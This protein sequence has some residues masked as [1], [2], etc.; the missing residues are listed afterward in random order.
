MNTPHDVGFLGIKIRIKTPKFLKSALKVAGQGVSA[1]G[2]VAKTVGDTIGK[3]PVIGTPLHALY[4][5]QT[6]QPFRIADSIVKGKR[7]DRI[8]YDEFKASIKNA[9]TI[10]PYA[11]SVVAMVPGIGTGA[12]GIIGAAN[13]LSKGQTIDKA[14]IEGVRGAVPGGVVARAA[15]DVGYAAVSGKGIDQIALAAIPLPPAQKAIIT[16]GALAL[17][18]IA[19]GKRVD[20]ALVMRAIEASPPDINTCFVSNFL[21]VPSRSFIS[22]SVSCFRL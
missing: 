13:A 19:E 17:K 10:A 3:V 12:A 2:S 1:V 11:Q 18:D 7:I 21:N 20:E 15:F 14:I 22:S 5:L 8:A 16:Q 6:G 4:D 9:Q